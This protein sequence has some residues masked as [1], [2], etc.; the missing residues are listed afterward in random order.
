MTDWRED[1]DQA[2][3]WGIFLISRGSARFG[4]VCG[5]IFDL[6]YQLKLYTGRSRTLMSVLR[7]VA[8]RA[9][10]GARSELAAAQFCRLRR[11]MPECRALCCVVHLLRAHLVLLLRL[12]QETG[13]SSQPQPPRPKP[14]D[15]SGNGRWLPVNTE[16]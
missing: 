8:L 13:L 14:S 1:G 5:E 16:R 11:N 7:V 3:T 6:R 15:R 2:K 12:A 9:V 10:A 4:F